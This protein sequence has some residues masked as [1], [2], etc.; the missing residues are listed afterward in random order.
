MRSELKVPLQFS[1]ARINGQNAGSVQ[2]VAG[3]CIPD[4]I[5][6]CIA[7]RPIQGIEFWVIG[8]RHPGRRASVQ[9]G[10]AGP[11]GGT[12]LSW[13]G[14][15]PEMPLEFARS[16]IVCSYEPADPRIATRCAD[17]HHAIYD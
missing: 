14:N 8:T 2:V 6:R 9:I 10:I 17:N 11:A 12:E 15:G 13:P 5:R 3:P 1:T 4:K 7:R 16:R